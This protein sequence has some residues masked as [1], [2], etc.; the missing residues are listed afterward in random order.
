M[1]ISQLEDIILQTVSNQSQTWSKKAWGITE[2]STGLKGHEWSQTNLWWWQESL[3]KLKWVVSLADELKTSTGQMVADVIVRAKSWSP[4]DIW[5][6]IRDNTMDFPNHKWEIVVFADISDCGQL[7]EL[8]NE[9]PETILGSMKKVKVVADP[10]SW[11]LMLMIDTWNEDAKKFSAYKN[12]AYS[13][14]IVYYDVWFTTT[15][16]AVKHWN[17]TNEVTLNFNIEITDFTEGSNVIKRLSCWWRENWQMLN[18][19]RNRLRWVNRNYA[20]YL[21]RLNTSVTKEE[22]FNTF[23]EMLEYGFF[24]KDFDKMFWIEEK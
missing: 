5:N 11:E 8:Q 6:L 1:S 4:E 3:G 7:Q 9:D 18:I 22:V 16:I 24:N 21:E 12:P 14:S 23:I 17:L 15:T 19:Y 10:Q 13:I 20:H 2:E